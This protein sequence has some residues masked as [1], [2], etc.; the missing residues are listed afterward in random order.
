MITLTELIKVQAYEAAVMFISGMAVMILFEIFSFIK[1]KSEM[2]KFAAA[3]F[4]LI[5]WAFAGLLTCAF[6]YR[7]AFGAISFHSVVAFILGVVLW[8]GTLYGILFPK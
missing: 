3:I 1:Y 2:K 8:K 5:L 7:A 6:L 4:E